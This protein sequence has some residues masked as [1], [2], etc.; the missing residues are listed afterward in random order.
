MDLFWKIADFPLRIRNFLKR[1]LARKS[2]FSKESQLSDSQV[3]FYEE[4]VLRVIN[5]DRLFSRFRRIYDYREILEHISYSLGK[6]YYSKVLSAFPEKFAQIQDFK[7]NDSVGRPRK[8]FFKGIGSVSP[9]T[10]RYLAVA[11]DIEKYLGCTFFNSVAEIG[12]GYGGQAQVLHTLKW[13]NKYDIYDLPP[14]QVLAR[15]YLNKLKSNFA[16]FPTFDSEKA[17]EYDLVISNYAFSELPREIQI[18]Y[19]QK[20][21]KNSKYGF[22]IM[23]SGLTNTTGRSEGK[24]ALE[25]IR[26]VIPN[27]RIRKEEPLTSPDNY[28]IIWKP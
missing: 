9:T 26:E 4:A 11:S 1:K 2:I 12:G 5:D 8:Y 6:K 21:I 22:M 7:L 24:L 14:V 20:V 25:E 23:N 18:S 27:L 16:T 28:L 13:V 10:I 15:K 3:T 17:H 19:L